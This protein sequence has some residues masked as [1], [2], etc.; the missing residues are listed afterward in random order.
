MFKW[1]ILLISLTTFNMNKDQLKAQLRIMKKIG[2]PVIRVAI[3]YV[4]KNFE[5]D[6]NNP[7]DYSNHS[8]FSKLAIAAL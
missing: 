5:R 1:S 3:E 8:R 2:S 4:K 6:K 7:L